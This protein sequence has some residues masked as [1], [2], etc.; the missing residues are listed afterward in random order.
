[1]ARRR[2]TFDEMRSD[3]NKPEPTNGVFCPRCGCGHLK[4]YGT[5][6]LTTG[7][8]QRYKRCRNCKTRFLTS[9]PPER[10]VREVES[11]EDED[12]G[13]VLKVRMA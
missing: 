12:E 7:S 2:L 9:Q 11:K 10:I 6:P 8:R 3:G 1:M 4:T 13:P 5:M